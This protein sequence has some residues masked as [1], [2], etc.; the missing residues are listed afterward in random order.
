MHYIV[1]YRFRKLTSLNVLGIVQLYQA[2]I[3]LHF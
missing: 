2:M 1:W 3:Q